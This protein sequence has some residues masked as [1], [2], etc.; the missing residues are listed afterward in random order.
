M[1]KSQNSWF[2]NDLSIVSK[3][4]GILV[5]KARSEKYISDKSSEKFSWLGSGA[6]LS[7]PK[8]SNGVEKVS[9]GVLLGYSGGVHNFF[10]IQVYD[11]KKWLEHML[12]LANERLYLTFPVRNM[13]Q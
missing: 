8:V 1:Q 7:T 12:F 4:I 2:C 5:L 6:G 10:K 11:A 13:F 9:N 3:A